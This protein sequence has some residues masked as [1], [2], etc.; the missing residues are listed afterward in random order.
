MV[1]QA[2]KEG[3]NALWARLAKPLTAMQNI[4]SKRE[5]GERT[6]ISAEMIENVAEI[7]DL[8]PNLNAT[9][10]AELEK[11]SN[12]IKALVHGLTKDDLSDD[13]KRRR[14]ILKRVADISRRMTGRKF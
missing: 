5:A 2:M 4:L 10:N 9:G 1:Q 13:E 3:E 14:E 6:K 7:A 11:F 12:E 8:I